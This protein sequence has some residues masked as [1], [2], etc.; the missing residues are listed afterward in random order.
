MSADP[1][2]A[3]PKKVGPKKAGPKKAGF[4]LHVQAP[5]RPGK[6][7]ATVTALDAAD[8][9]KVLATHRANLADQGELRKAARH[10]AAR[11]G[12]DEG[13]L[14]EKLH[15]AWVEV[16]TAQKKQEAEGEPPPC[17]PYSP[18]SPYTIEGGRICRLARGPGGEEY[19]LALCNFNATIAEDVR[20]DDGSGEVQHTFTV[21]G[22]LSDGTPLPAAEV[23]AQDLAGMAWVLDAWGSAAIVAPG[24]GAKDHL[25]A[26]VQELSAGKTRHRTVYAHTGWRQIGEGWAY[27]HAGGAI[28]PGGALTGLSVE[29]SG[30]L[31][32]FRLPDP[33]SGEGLAE[34]VRGSLRLLELAPA[35]VIV[36]L[37]GAVYRAVL[38]GVDFSLHLVGQSG[39]GKS[40]LSALAQQHYGPQM[41]RDRLPGNWE[42][43]G[44]ALE[45]L[46]FGAK[47]ALLVV[48]DF[49]PRGGRA[50]L[51]GWHSKAD[52]LFRSQGNSSA[53]GRCWSDGRLRAARPPRGLVLSSGEDSP[54]GESCRARL[55]TLQL[56]KGDFNLRSL[57][58]YQR[59]AAEGLYAAALAGFVRW[60]APRYEEVRSGLAAE[61]AGLRKKALSQGGHP[62]APGIVAD[63]ALGWKYLLDFA[64]EVG[65]VTPDQRAELERKAWRALLLAAAEQAAETADQ[66]P[67]RT[68]LRLL[69]ACLTKGRGY[70][71]HPRI[72]LEPANPSAWGWR[73]H[74]E[75]VSQQEAV[76]RWRSAG[77]LLGSG[78]MAMTSTWTPRPS[79]P[80]RCA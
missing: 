69:A 62:R 59:D 52:R 29:L 7:K 16:L 5:A 34:A 56:S 41:A 70:L 57:T 74:E 25:R 72:G 3:G 38:G 63:L 75:Q 37:L 78:S 2:R 28:G 1:K 11:L 47:D 26:A 19:M 22:A 54:R 23:R 51:D 64:A 27:L 66:S 9:T 49:K 14:E 76:V 33:P 58:P 42:S 8:R 40:E 30:R 55:L 53:R 44:N 45:A 36:P 4:I 50:E 6:G 60:L 18:C 13:A 68:F 73:A 17:S 77:S 67:A 43:T 24:Q 65:A 80:R 79:T 35:R 39:A 21:E 61:R 20:R 31:A 46:C 10:L 71:A 12:A 32:D 48:D 15:A